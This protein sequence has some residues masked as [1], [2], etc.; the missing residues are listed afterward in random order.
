MSISIIE[1][2]NNFNENLNIQL[3]KSRNQIEYK[4][5]D[6][7]NFSYEQAHYVI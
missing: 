1:T 5:N 4:Y 3:N 6:F 7:C 2:N